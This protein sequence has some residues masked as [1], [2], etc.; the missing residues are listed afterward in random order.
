MF[1]FDI[2]SIFNISVVKSDGR[3]SHIKRPQ[4]VGQICVRNMM[5]DI[6]L[7]VSDHIIG[8]DIRGSSIVLFRQ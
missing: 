6:P 7:S 4:H 5:H 1:K 3:V 2:V 8:I